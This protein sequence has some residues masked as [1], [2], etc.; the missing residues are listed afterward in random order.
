MG[1]DSKFSPA[2]AITL[3]GL[4]VDERS[5]M[6]KRLDGTLIPGLYAA[7][8]TAVGLASGSYVSGLSIGDC[9]FSGRRAGRSAAQEGFASEQKNPAY[10]ASPERMSL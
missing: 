7:G 6:V 10:A 4:I 3:G 5:G 9:V 8:R 2:V 1:T